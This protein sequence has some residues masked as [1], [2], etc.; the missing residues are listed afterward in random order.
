MF[1]LNPNGCSHIPRMHGADNGA[2]RS[3]GRPV[4]TDASGTLRAVPL[5]LCY[6]ENTPTKNDSETKRGAAWSFLA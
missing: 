4:H 6:T 2:F 3:P 1:H 5:L